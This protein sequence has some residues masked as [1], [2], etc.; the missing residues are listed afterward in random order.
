MNIRT[1]KYYF[2]GTFAKNFLH[3]LSSIIKF[4]RVIISFRVLF[5]SAAV[6]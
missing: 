1:L 5:N 3:Y 6:S 2:P 4:L